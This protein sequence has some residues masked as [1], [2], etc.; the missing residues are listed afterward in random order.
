MHRLYIEKRSRDANLLVNAR[1]FYNSPERSLCSNQVAYT[2]KFYKHQA[3]VKL[4]QHITSFCR[5]KEK[6]RYMYQAIKTNRTLTHNTRAAQREAI[7]IL[8]RT[9]NY[10]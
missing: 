10:F 4:E 9:T 7:I 2:Q 6:R 5:R 8:Y 3:V 1:Q